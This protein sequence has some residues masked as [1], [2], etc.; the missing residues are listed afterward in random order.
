MRVA[1]VMERRPR[2]VR[3]HDSLAEAAQAMRER[4][5]GFLPVL[6]RGGRVVGVIT[7]RDIA[8]AAE[9]RGRALEEISVGGSMHSDVH[10]CSPEQSVEDALA[11]MQ[12]FRVRR[13]PVVDAGGVLVGVLSLSALARLAD[14]APEGQQSP[15][16]A[17]IAH[18]LAAV[19]EPRAANHYA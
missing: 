8:L 15:S 4:R 10:A 2:S 11:A 12:S 3:P 18:T 19:A 9:E 1:E 7:D 17:A 5:C 6:G 13:I 16:R 14:S